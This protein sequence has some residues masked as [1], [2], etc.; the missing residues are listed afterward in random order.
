MRLLLMFSSLFLAAAG[1][2]VAQPAPHAEQEPRPI[3][4]LSAEQVEQYLSGV[5]MGF[6]SAMELNHYPGSKHVLEL[7]DGLQLSTDQIEQTRATFS[8][9]K[10]QA[11]ALGSLIVER[12]RQF[13][14]LFSLG[15]IDEGQIN[16]LSEEVALCRAACGPPTYA[17]TSRGKKF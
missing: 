16:Q 1:P 15:Q 12:E 7:V 13:D 9:M 6:A 2:S 8:Q 10:H 17:L 14:A 5:E 4:A 3:K 11:V